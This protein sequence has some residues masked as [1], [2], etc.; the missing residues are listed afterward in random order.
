M[1]INSDGDKV[2]T[3]L[4]QLREQNVSRA[5][6]WHSDADPWSLA[7]WSNAMCGE[8]GEAA[9]IVKKIRRNETSIGSSYNT[10]KTKELIP[11]LAEELADIVI[12]A[13]L[14]ADQAGINLENAIIDKFNK[15][16]KAQNFPERLK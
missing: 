9:N 5:K 7:D 3:S 1:F 8:T 12:Y 10:P 14:L 11:K 16:S 13:D 6:R 15:V 2:Y 4:K